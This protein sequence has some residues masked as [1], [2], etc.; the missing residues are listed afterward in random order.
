MGLILPSW[1]PGTAKGIKILGA[2]IG[3]QNFEE[4]QHKIFATKIEDDLSRL[5]QF[6]YLQSVLHQPPHGW[7]QNGIS[8]FGATTRITQRA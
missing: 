8:R 7:A 5:Q 2:P 6:P 3:K 4:E 1:V